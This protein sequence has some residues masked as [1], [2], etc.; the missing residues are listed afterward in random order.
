MATIFGTL[1]L[2]MY[3]PI[4]LKI[5]Y[6]SCHK[7]LYIMNM[8]IVPLFFEL[9]KKQESIPRYY[10]PTRHEDKTMFFF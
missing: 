2:Y 7:E 4:A 3:L 8:N 6:E 10:S 5:L 1:S 9:K